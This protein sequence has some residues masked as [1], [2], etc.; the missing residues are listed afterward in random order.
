ML[1]ART[2]YDE[3]NRVIGHRVARK[4][5][6]IGRLDNDESRSPWLPRHQRESLLTVIRD[7]RSCWRGQKLAGEKE[8]RRI[9]S[10]TNELFVFMQ[11][12]CFFPPFF[13][14]PPLH[15]TTILSIQWRCNNARETARMLE[16]YCAALKLRW[17]ICESRRSW[18]ATSVSRSSNE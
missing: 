4:V 15:F 6:S 17:W 13:L 2:R 14:S 11:A 5:L 3:S 9:E 16:E 18:F 12:G 7:Q 8:R 10:Y 1:F